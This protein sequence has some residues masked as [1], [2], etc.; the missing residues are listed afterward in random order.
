MIFSKNGATVSLPLESQ[1]ARVG[2]LGSGR[3][4][5]LPELPVERAKGSLLAFGWLHT[6]S[7]G[8]RQQKSWYVCF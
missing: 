2:A 3:I 7:K 1:G 8:G 4:D 6:A 5:R